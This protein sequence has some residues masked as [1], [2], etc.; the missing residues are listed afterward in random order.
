MTAMASKKITSISDLIPDDRNA[1]R[2]TERGTGAIEKSVRKYGVGRSIL[3]NADG[4]ILAG[5]KTLQTV[6]DLGMDILPVYTDGKKLVV[7]IRQDLDGNSPEAI[8]KETELAIAD[9]HCS[10]VGLEWDTEVLQTLADVGD[11]DLTEFFNKEELALMEIVLKEQKEEKE[12]SEQKQLSDVDSEQKRVTTG[13]IWQLGSHY[14]VCGD[15]TDK[16]FVVDA[17][18]KCGYQLDEVKMVWSDPPY[19]C[20]AQTKK[21]KVSHGHKTTK[22]TNPCYPIIEGDTTNDTAI[23]AYKLYS[24]LFSSAKQIWWGANFYSEALPSAP[25]WLVWDKVVSDKMTFGKAELAFTNHTTNSV[26]LF[27]HQWSGMLKDGVER[28]KKR[29]HP[30]QKP[31]ALFQYVAENY[32]GEDD[33]II[34]PFNGSGCAI[35]GSHNMIGNRVVI[36]FEVMPVYCDITLERFEKETGMSVEK[37]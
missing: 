8:K 21:G 25:A 26:D 17:I 32:G 4:K 14:L 13:D 15:S 31:E 2:G 35:M 22:T 37:L 29:C 30:N 1:N 16:D 5:N 10:H 28:G 3:A 19:G 12:P 23:A 34:D 6:S 27:R 11:A 9:N 24:S 7:V 18:G 33:L 36:A 20:E